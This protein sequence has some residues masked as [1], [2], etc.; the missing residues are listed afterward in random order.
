MLPYL[1]YEQKLLDYMKRQSITTT[2]GALQNSRLVLGGTTGSGGGSGGPI[3][4]F[5]GQLVQTSVTFDESEL[6]TQTI[7]SSGVSLLDNLNRIRAAVVI[8]P[9]YTPINY[10]VPSGLDSTLIDHLSG[11]DEVVLS[12]TASGVGHTIQDEGIGLPQRTYLNFTGAGVTVTDDAGNDQTDVTISGGAGGASWPFDTNVITVDTTDADADYD[13]LSDA[14]SAASSGDLIL[15]SPETHT[16][17]GLTLSDGVHLAGHGIGATIIQTSSSTICITIGDGCQV[18]D[19]TIKNTKSTGNPQ[20]VSMAFNDSAE[21][22]HVR[23]EV[24]SSAS[25]SAYAFNVKENTKL[26]ACEGYVDAS[27]SSGANAIRANGSAGNKIIVEGGEYEADDYDVSIGADITVVLLYARLINGTVSDTGTG[28]L[29]GHWV[30]DDGEQIGTWTPTVYQGGDVS[31]TVTRAVYQVVGSAVNTQVML[32]VT[33]TGSAANA[34]EIRSCPS[35][36]APVG[37]DVI[38]TFML[39]NVGTAVY[40]GAVYP[41]SPAVWQL[42]AHNTGNPVGISPSFALA[43]GDVIRLNCTY[44]YR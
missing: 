21:F 16:C 4:P 36:I 6:A 34:V 38:G 17:N 24:V 7:P 32:A 23:A 12:G 22:R 42:W 14:I 31:V 10:T 2:M 20:A 29:E 1:E 39:A 25:G 40:V 13:N 9:I 8:R 33:G 11:I 44:R 37:L 27:S 30:G 35:G 41:T 28:V 5:I 19:L 43:S 3:Q 15:L 26:I 18:R